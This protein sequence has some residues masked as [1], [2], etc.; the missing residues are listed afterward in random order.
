MVVVPMGA[1]AAASWKCRG[2]ALEILLLPVAQ[3]SSHIASCPGMGQG[4]GTFSLLWCSA[5]EVG[6]ELVPAHG[7]CLRSY[8]GVERADLGLS[9][10]GGIA[11]ALHFWEGALLQSLLSPGVVEGSDPREQHCRGALCHFLCP[12]LLK[13]LG[14]GTQCV[15]PEVSWRSK[16]SRLAALLP[17]GFYMPK[18]WLW[19]PEGTLES[20][21][22]PAL[23]SCSC[24]SWGWK[25]AGGPIQ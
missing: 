3:S 9:P 22:L 11:F 13:L 15:N 5:A 24:L 6:L 14:V 8:V 21:Q 4:S 18:W 10:A 23:V 20:S 7:W 16:L 19:L 17:P 2:G 25:D 1:Q 12:A